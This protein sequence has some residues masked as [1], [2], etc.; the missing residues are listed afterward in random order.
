[1]K[2][3][4]TICAVALLCTPLTAKAEVNKFRPE[5]KL[6]LDLNNDDVIDAID[7]SIVLREYAAISSG[8]ESSFSVTDMYTADY[9]CDGKVDSVDASGIL[10]Y[11]AANA[12]DN[13]Q[14]MTTLLFTPMI[15]VNKV[16]K[17]YGDYTSY[18]EAMKAMEL[19]KQSVIDDHFIYEKCYV[20]MT[21]ITMS[22]L[23]S[24][25]IKYIHEDL[26]K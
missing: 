4:L 1:M 5:G 19:G 18:E 6:K 15:K 10:A 24:V 7:A 8:Q 25:Q 9:N 13:E 21:Q 12:T 26:E 17:S 2:K 16:T 22:D 3:M 23:P 14:A 20:Q 11:Y